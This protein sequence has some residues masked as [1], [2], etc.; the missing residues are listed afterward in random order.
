MGMEVLMAK[1]GL[2]AVCDQG[3]RK[4]SR[5]YTCLTWASAFH[6]CHASSKRCLTT[7]NKKLLGTSSSLLV[8]GALLV[9]TSYEF[10]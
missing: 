3:H 6:P 9:V 8:T 5:S 1:T 4:A 2:L 10:N 7:S